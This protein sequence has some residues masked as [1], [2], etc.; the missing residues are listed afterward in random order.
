MR[1]L[2]PWFAAV[3]ACTRMLPVEAM[4]PAQL[5]ARL[6]APAGFRVGVFAQGLPS[7]RAMAWG[8]KGTLF[9][10][11]SDAG[12]V[13]ALR[14][15]DHDGR[16]DAV[17]I[18]ARGLRVPLG[19]AFRGGSLYVSSI[20][21]ILRFDNIEASLDTPPS[22]VTV[23][24][25]LPQ[26]GHHGGRYLAF[27]PD[28]KLYVPIGAPCN[29]CDRPGF[30]KLTRMN[31]AGRGRD[32]PVREDVAFGIRNTVGFAWN[33]GDGKLWFTDNGRDLLGDDVPDDELNVVAS[34]GQHFGFPYC[35]GGNV[36][37]PEFGKGKSCRDYTPPAATLGA[38]VAPL[39]IAFYTGR[40]FPAAYRGN[41][42]IA[43]HGSWNRSTKSGYRVVVATIVG[44]KVVKIVPFL[45]GF[46]DGQITLGRPVAVIN[47]PD[48]SLLVSDD[49]AG[50][51]YRISYSATRTRQ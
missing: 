35:H 12:V 17:K 7:A 29:V 46:L 2:L 22:P 51:I 8:D 31:P 16:A 13:Y 33:P 11:S 44:D 38:H 30:A 41:L 19:V 32:R 48:G 4:P 24:A 6:Q 9:V 5:A 21:R 1:R 14:D 34:R 20:D 3:F 26:D 40:Q 47:A 49:Y 15:A 27:G 10:G 18:V 23:V 36:P 50:A 28:G 42:F 37:D 45:T 25:D 39:G 43:E